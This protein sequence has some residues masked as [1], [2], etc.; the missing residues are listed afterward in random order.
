MKKEHISIIVISVAV[1]LGLLIGFN[2]NFFIQEVN[3]DDLLNSDLIISMTGDEEDQ[4]ESID[5]WFW[6]HLFYR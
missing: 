4:N 2:D 5:K 6:Q 1:I 3:S